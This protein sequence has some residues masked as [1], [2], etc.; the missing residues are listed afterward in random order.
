MS[1]EKKS[2]PERNKERETERIAAIQ[3]ICIDFI[4]TKFTYKI[5]SY[6]Y[7]YGNKTNNQELE[8]VKFQCHMKTQAQQMTA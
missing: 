1:R 2:D 5:S 3:I 8:Q 7:V 6:R 4:I